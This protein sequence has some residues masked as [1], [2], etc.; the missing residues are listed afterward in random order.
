MS[1]GGGQTKSIPQ[2]GCGFSGK[3]QN[4]NNTNRNIFQEVI[5]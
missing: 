4:D 3:M 5:D 2:E 1:G